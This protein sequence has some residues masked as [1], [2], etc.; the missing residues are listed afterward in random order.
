MARRHPR[1]AL[2]KRRSTRTPLALGIIAVPRKPR[3]SYGGWRG[4]YD[5][6]AHLNGPVR[7]YIPGQPPRT[8]PRYA[9]AYLRRQVFSRDKGQCQYCASDVTYNACNIDHVQP[10]P[11]GQTVLSNLV[12]SCQDCNALKAR[13]HIPKAL[14][15]I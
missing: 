7:S 12:V 3:A 9:D 10:Y 5:G 15:P 14:R 4:L 13:Q 11:W 1:D 2:P 6:V 8:L